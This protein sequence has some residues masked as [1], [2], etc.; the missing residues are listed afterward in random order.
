[1]VAEELFKIFQNNGMD[2]SLL[3][4][5]K[6]MN[7]DEAAVY[8]KMSKKTLYNNI[9]S[10]PHVKRGGKLIFKEGSLRQYMEGC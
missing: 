1:M 8:L 10:I 5:E 7:T 4:P 6:Y 9:E 3:T 2:V